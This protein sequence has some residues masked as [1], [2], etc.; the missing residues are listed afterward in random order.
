MTSRGS[1]EL[2][3]FGLKTEKV[4]FVNAFRILDP[5]LQILFLR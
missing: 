2:T 4:S 5:G 3:A 1:D